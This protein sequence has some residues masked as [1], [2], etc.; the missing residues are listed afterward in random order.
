MSAAVAPG[1]DVDKRQALVRQLA[2]AKRMM[3]AKKARE[4]LIT[5]AKLT[6][7][8]PDDPDDIERS[9]YRDAKH[10][11][12]VAA[13]LEM[14]EKGL[15]P[16]LIITL[17]PRHGKSELVSRRFIAWL[18]GR[19][20]YRQ[21]IFATYSDTFATDFGREV[22]HIIRSNVFGQ[23]FP[24]VGI[25]KGEA[26]AD[27]IKMDAGGVAVFVGKGGAITGRGADFL[28]I[29]DLIKDAEEA[30]SP[31]MREKAWEWFTKVAMTRLMSVGACVVICMTRWHEDDIVGRL[32][33]PKNPNYDPE[34]AAKWKIIDLPALA[35]DNDVL[36]R[37]PGEALWP[38][39]FPVE[40]LTAQRRLNPRGF[41]A[42]YQQKPTPE[43]GE[44]F[45]RAW[46]KTYSPG[47][48][49]TGRMM[50]YGASD[51]AV[52]QDKKKHDRTVLLIVGVDEAG[53]IWILDCWIGR[54]DAMG[55]TERMIDMMEL[56]EPLFWWAEKGHISMSIG[57]FL[58]KRMQERGVYTA[59]E[60]VPPIKNKVQRAQAIQGRMA[61]GKVRFPRTAP[62]F[63]E[64]LDEMMKFPLGA[65]DDFVDALAWVGFKL[66]RQVAGKTLAPP[67]KAPP[68]VGTAAWMKMDSKYREEQAAR[69]HS[70]GFDG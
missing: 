2:A 64:A 12:A 67:K 46:V 45:K 6:Q 57:P 17:P 52:G 55:V 20:P 9:T 28:V 13:A 3:R 49:P 29:D 69:Q 51:H 25:R 39:R 31:T 59:I 8:H 41:N 40:W 50:I 62:W 19:D 36:G 27:R 70:G 53:D 60:E 66:Q 4:D 16:R 5:F 63:S 54:E 37:A 58:H 21:V 33:D 61:M 47:E 38:E 48:A 1:S 23:I 65:H 10:H 18:L 32:T 11:R 30:E 24:G 15:F 56:H 14:V 42:L 68:K 26:A 43:D 44:F 35:Y 34:E 22:R 7:P